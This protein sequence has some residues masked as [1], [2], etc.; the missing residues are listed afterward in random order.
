M[1]RLLARV[2]SRFVGDERA[3]A[4]VEFVLTVPVLMLIFMSS[5]ESG[6]LMTRQILLEQSLDEV[7]RDLRLGKIDSPNATKIKNRICAKS[8]IFTDCVNS[9]SVELTPIDGTSWTL[10]SA[11]T[12]CSERDD[13][14][15][16]PVVTFVPG[17]ENEMML[18]RVCV[19]QDA[20]FP[21]TGLGADLPLDNQGGYGLIAI[22]AFVN[23]P[24]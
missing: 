7:M 5:F 18:V 9:T 20:M 22:S 4:S 24:S 16:Q 17:S 12:A 21:T 10:P 2:L 8:I 13:E 3:T 19:V 6:L 15:V 23:E 11:N 1:K 14:A